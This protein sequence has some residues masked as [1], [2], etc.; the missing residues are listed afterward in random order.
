MEEVIEKEDKPSPEKK[1]LETMP[2]VMGWTI[3][4]PITH[5]PTIMLKDAAGIIEEVGLI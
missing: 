3:T 5:H 4:K 1:K 2:S